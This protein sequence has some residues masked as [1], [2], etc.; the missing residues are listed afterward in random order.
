[1]GYSNIVVGTDGSATAERAV[2]HAAALAVADGARVIVVTAFSSAV[3]G[4]GVGLS[5]EGIPDDLRFVLS[6]SVQA[7]TLA[8]RG[9]R[10][11]KDAGVNRVVLQAIEG[12]PSSVLLEA[13]RDFD[14]DLIVVG[15]KGL[16]SAAHFILGSVASSV[17]HHA[18]CD[19]LIAHTSD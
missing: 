19:V 15:S 4:A 10:R 1:M 11:L 6:G 18:P 7:E 9:R 8:E 17:S 12:D 5:D 13:A 16:T 3:T 14:A 2:D